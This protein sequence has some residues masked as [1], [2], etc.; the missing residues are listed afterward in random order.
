M[1]FYPFDQYHMD[2]C[3]QMQYGIFAKAV[4]HSGHAWNWKAQM[5][6]GELK[7]LNL[8][9]Y[10]DKR[11]GSRWRV[12]LTNM[13]ADGW[14]FHDPYQHSHMLQ[15]VIIIP[16][17]FGWNIG[18]MNRATARYERNWK[19]VQKWLKKANG[20]TFAISERTMILPVRFSADELRKKAR[21]TS[22]PGQRFE[23][24]S[25]AQKTLQ[26]MAKRTNPNII[27]SCALYTGD[28]DHEE[29]YGSAAQGNALILSSD[30]TAISITDPPQ[31][32]R[33]KRAAY[34][35]AHEYLHCLGLPHTD[36]SQGSDWRHSIMIWGE[37]DEAILTQQEKNMIRNNPH[38][39]GA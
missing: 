37:P 5:P 39:K 33:E 22:L 24:L 23:L 28:E 1:Q 21:D 20:S 32:H 14:W 16:D 29:D 27:Y 25:W 34:D 7:G 8:Q 4:N 13:G 17:Y 10:S 36:E 12:T 31:E 18:M 30:N 2:Q 6:N 35:M 11:Y 26:D 19:Y 9:A 38:L 3:A 15:P